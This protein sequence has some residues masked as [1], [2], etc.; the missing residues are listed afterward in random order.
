MIPRLFSILLIPLFLTPA[1]TKSQHRGEGDSFLN[2]YSIE[3]HA[4]STP[5]DNTGTAEILYRIRYDFFIFS[6]SSPASENFTADAEITI[7][8]LNRDNGSVFRKIIQTD[9][10]S[11][12]SEADSLRSRN[13][14]GAVTARI[15]PGPYTIHC[16]IIDRQSRRQISDR[17]PGLVIP[18]GIPAS[19]SLDDILFTETSGDTSRSWIPVNRGGNLVFGNNAFCVLRLRCS[20]SLRDLHTVL[21]ITRPGR[22]GGPADTITTDSLPRIIPPDGRIFRPVFSDTSA[23]YRME[24]SSAPG[25][26]MI[27]F[28]VPGD[29]L[30]Q[31]DYEFSVSCRSGAHTVV[32]RHQHVAIIWPDKPRTLRNRTTAVEALEYLLPPGDFDKLSHAK[33]DEQDRLF[34]K[35]WKDLDPTPRTAWNELQA[36]YYRR[37]DIAM[38]QYATY[39]QPDGM[40]TDRGRIYMLYG[41]PSSVDRELNPGGAPQEIWS[42]AGLHRQF[43]FRDNSRQ[44]NYTLVQ[45]I[46]H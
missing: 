18:D 9:L 1:V 35:F 25:M 5:G 3:F 31:G 28:A 41:P 45:E 43:I 17:I 34:R 27:V 21:T 16:D 46:G 19:P 38:A 23:D 32:S 39:H 20:D 40:R 44:G 36:E 42:Y 14:Q 4:W 30:E 7:E 26:R 29:T 6:R 13:L 15:A 12:T 10:S 24:R 2:P 11:A 33:G 22:E 8:L 37:A